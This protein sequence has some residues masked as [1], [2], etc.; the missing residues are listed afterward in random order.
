MQLALSLELLG[1]AVAGIYLV[2]GHEP[3][4]SLAI[5]P[6]ALHLTIRTERPDVRAPGHVRPLAPREPEPVEAVDDVLLVGERRPDHVRVFHSEH[7]RAPCMASE[8]VVEEGRSG[9]SDMELAGGARCEAEPNGH[10]AD[11][12]GL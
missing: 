4:R 7:E 12:K 6:E 2:L 1:R 3:T 11:G 5:D 10:W 8:E 9:G